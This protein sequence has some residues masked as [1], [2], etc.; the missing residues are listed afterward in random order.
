MSIYDMIDFVKNGEIRQIN[1][2]ETSLGWVVMGQSSPTANQV[3][4]GSSSGEGILFC[5]AI[6]QIQA[7]QSDPG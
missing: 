4:L 1:V 5:C 2:T 6:P 3:H 7:F